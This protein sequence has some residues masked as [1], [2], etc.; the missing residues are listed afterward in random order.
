MFQQSVSGMNFKTNLYSDNFD[1]SFRV[2]IVFC[3]PAAV[4]YVLRFW[5][6][7]VEMFWNNNKIFT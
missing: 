3:F 6:I 5:W 4:S 2:G 1:K 7:L